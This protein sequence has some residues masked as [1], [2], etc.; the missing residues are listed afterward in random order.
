MLKITDIEQVL[1]DNLVP[2]PTIVKIVNSL[3]AI[4]ADNKP[5][6]TGVKQ[7]TQFAVILNDAATGYVIQ[8]PETE[9]V[10]LIPS[11]LRAA[12]TEFNQSKRARKRPIK[13]WGDLFATLPPKYL[14]DK[15]VKIKTRQFVQLIT[16]PTF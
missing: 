9:D 6:P 3:E 2:V 4:E 1:R 14:R 16:P 10:G 13:G 7:K 5:E 8:L 12:A 15:K 11:I